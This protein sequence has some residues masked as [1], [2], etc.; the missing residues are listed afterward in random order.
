MINI[1]IDKDKCIG[2]GLCCKKNKYFYIGKDRK[3]NFALK[4]ESDK[5]FKKFNFTCPTDAIKYE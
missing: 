5:N 3:A 1:K 2:C 4:N